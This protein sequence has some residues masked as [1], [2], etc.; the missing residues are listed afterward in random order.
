MQKAATYFEQVPK[1]EMKKI[2]AQ[3]EVQV[4]NDQED[5]TSD[6]ASFRHDNKAIPLARKR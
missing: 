4:E 1:A 2:L 6:N 3:L 5:D